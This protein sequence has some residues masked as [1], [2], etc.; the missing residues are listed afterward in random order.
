MSHPGSSAAPLAWILTGDKSG[1]AAQMRALAKAGGLRSVEMPLDYNRR[2]QRA[3]IFLGASLR[4]LKAPSRAQI[5]PPWPDIVLSS[6]RRSVPI[7]R[8]I[9]RQSGGRTRLVHVGRPWG[10]LAWFDLVLAMPQYGLPDRD[11]VMQ[12]RMPFNMPSPEAMAAARERWR[13]RLDAL[14]RPWIALLVGGKSK[15]LRLD[16]Q[17]AA[18]IG[19][20]AS[21]LAR[22]KGGSVLAVTS[23]RTSPEATAALFAAIDAPGI[24]HGWRANDPE[25]PYQALLALADEFVVTGDSASMLAESLRTGR[26]VSIAPLPVRL[27]P[28]RRRIAFFRSLLPR[29]LFAL[30]IDLGL[31][32]SVRDMTLLQRRLVAD[33]VAVMLGSQAAG[34]AGFADDMPAAAERV[35]ALA[36]TR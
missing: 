7:A 31:V 23:P 9:R 26:P 2:Y 30:L 4:S 34:R 18:D 6:G 3:N 20:A 12:L 8:W 1:D 24:R 5:A 11:N 17:I 36:L 27:G 28:K 21:R 15:P 10:R 25:S 19:R 35:R 14:P 32:T 16:A 22:E 13:D 29:P 33:G